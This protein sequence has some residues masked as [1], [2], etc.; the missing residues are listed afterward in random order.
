MAADTKEAKASKEEIAITPFGVEID[1]PRNCDLVI[2]AIPGAK[3]RS[4]IKPTVTTV[5]GT[6]RTPTASQI[7]PPSVPGLRLYINPLRGVYRIVDP[8]VEDEAARERIEKYMKA[9]GG[10]TQPVKGVPTLEAKL[11]EHR[12]KSLLREIADLL[13][14]QHV[15]VVEGRAPSRAEIDSMPGNYLLNPGSRVFNSQPV[16][17]KDWDEWVDRLTRSGS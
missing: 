5:Q 6:V 11:D 14:Q 12:M 16:F 9:T 13:D 17:E 3:L 10:S 4:A 8:L 7:A 1:H 15:K 2:Q